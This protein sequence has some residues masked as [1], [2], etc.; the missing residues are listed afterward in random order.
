MNSN[1]ISILKCNLK[2][3]YFCVL[4]NIVSSNALSVTILYILI[5]S[6]KMTYFVLNEFTCFIFVRYITTYYYFTFC[7]GLIY[8]I[9]CCNVYVIFYEIKNLFFIDKYVI[10]LL[11]NLNYC[12]PI[13]LEKSLDNNWILENLCFY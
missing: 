13:Q 10:L 1:F 11:F 3:I 7:N 2:V 8:N 4:N 5:H 12:I 6:L 9:I